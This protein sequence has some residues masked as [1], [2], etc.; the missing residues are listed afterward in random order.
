MIR[1]R[2]L[3][4]LLALAPWVA[5]AAVPGVRD[6]AG[7][8]LVQ[9]GAD[10][11]VAV[12]L[13]GAARGRQQS[14][15]EG[16]RLP[17]PPVALVAGRWLVG[18]GAEADRGLFMAFDADGERLFLMLLLDGGPIYLAPPRVARWPDELAETFAEFA[19]VCPLGLAHGP[20]FTD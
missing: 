18:W 19:A 4:A 9:L 5:R 2:T 12:L 11:A 13:R 10:P 6:R 20:R 8:T 14:V 1:R 16:L 3:G 17:G 7:G 15:Y